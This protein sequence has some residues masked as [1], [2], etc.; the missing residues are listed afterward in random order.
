MKDT[1][2]TRPVDLAPILATLCVA[3]LCT[4][5]LVAVSFV[6]VYTV[7]PFQEGYLGSSLNGLYFVVLTGVGATMLY[8]LLKRKHVKLVVAVTGFALTAAAFLLST[9]YLDAI[10]SVT[11]VYSFLSTVGLDSMAIFAFVIVLSII[12]TILADWTIFRGHG[13]STN[14]L[15]LLIGGGLG[16]FLGAAIPVFSAIVILVFL[17]IYDIYAVYRGPVGKI[18]QGGLDRLKGMSLWFRDVQI[19]LGDL[20]F[21]SMLIGIVLT[22]TFN[23]ENVLSLFF[24]AASAAGILIGSFL[25]FK[26]LERKGMFPGLPFPIALGLVPLIVWFVL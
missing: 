3:I 25:A 22:T 19:G 6:G 10:F 20:T 16:A 18:A 13:K 9:I 24:T 5:L 15:V 4:Y 11:G 14:V 7:A 2:K 1:F 8:L 23:A 21:Y 17:A 12:A 26:M